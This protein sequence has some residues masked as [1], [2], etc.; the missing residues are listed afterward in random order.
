MEKKEDTAPEI[1]EENVRIV[2]KK[3]KHKGGSHGG[4][5]KVAYA[6]FVTALMA[7]F[8]VLWL[9]SQSSSVKA[10]IGQ[11][12]TDPG[13]FKTSKYKESKIEA[14]TFA[15]GSKKSVDEVIK[16]FDAS[17]IGLIK[18]LQKFKDI[19]QDAMV[20]VTP[21]GLEIEFSD[22]D[23]MIFFK[24]GSAEITDDVR[25]KIV[26][27]FSDMPK[28]NYPIIIEG[29]TDATPTGRENYTNWE[30]SGDRANALRRIIEDMNVGKVVEVKAYG[31]SRLLKT[32]SPYD[33]SNRRVNFIIKMFGE[34]ERGDEKPIEEK[35]GE[36]KEIEH[37]E[38][39][40]S[41]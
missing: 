30:L 36:E 41:H 21:D 31:S 33:A 22:T 26:S 1:P 5:W 10:Y 28:I 6:D 17:Q 19:K 2:V 15:H 3:K 11:Y 37:E 23:K 13:S 27:A 39:K 20:D 7:L 8:I 34:S 14:R 24:S 18:A 32:D 29:H 4:A 16:N 38:K 9:T 12:F 35:K 25:A 40:G